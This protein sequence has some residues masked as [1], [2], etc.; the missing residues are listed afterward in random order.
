MKRRLMLEGVGIGLLLLAPG[1]GPL[2]AQG[3][4]R[5]ILIIR[6][7]GRDIGS[8]TFRIVSDS[9]GLRVT[10]RAVYGTRGPTTLT[11]SLD[12]GREGELA[13]QLDRRGPQVGQVF[14]VQK[15]NRITVR[16][17]ER[18]AE[19][20]SELPAVA[21]IVILADSV[22]SLFAQLVPLAVDGRPIPALFPLGTR[23]LSLTLA[24]VA[25]G[26]GSLVRFRGGL[27]GEIELGSHGELLR[28]QLSSTGL[29]ALRKRD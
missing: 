20:A 29:E 14:A 16:R 3:E 5:G 22:F 23:R 2:S 18:G 21:G 13:F 17:V 11:A 24:R 7:G 1:A 9:A 28:I 27:E 26:A 4:D 15:R 19:Q 8:E 6:A 10:A 25:A 12:R